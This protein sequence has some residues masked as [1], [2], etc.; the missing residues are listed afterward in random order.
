[1]ATTTLG[2]KASWPPAPRPLL[3]PGEAL[4]EE[5]LAPLAHDLPGS[6]E[7]GG[8]LVVTQALGS[9]EDYSGSD[10]VSIL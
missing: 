10:D 5:S 9:V 3:E 2:G 1:M 6:V 8:D 7:P 4:L